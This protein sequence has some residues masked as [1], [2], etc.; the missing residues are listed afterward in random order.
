M[1]Y[2]DSLTT[3]S[4]TPSRFIKKI[5]EG[6]SKEQIISEELELQI[7]YFKDRYSS[8][9]QLKMIVEAN[10]ID[11]SFDKNIR[12]EELMNQGL[13]HSKALNKANI[14]IKKIWLDKCL[15]LR[16]EVLQTQLPFIY[17]SI[18]SEIEDDLVKDN[19]YIDKY[20][21]LD[22]HKYCFDIPEYN[23]KCI[24]LFSSLLGFSITP[25]T[26]KGEYLL[27]L[28]LYIC[29]SKKYTF[30]YTEDS[31]EQKIINKQID[32]YKNYVG[33]PELWHILT[34]PL[35]DNEDILPIQN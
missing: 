35:P 26:L 15:S 5:K 20:T 30:N 2:S 34:S 25:I 19:E 28:N 11:I 21:S 23:K 10:N 4:V 8:F 9:K 13:T 17:D 32:N 7:D 33:D 6:I 31:L 12:I 3:V 29:N 18:F 16:A 24:I 1:L 22:F 14:E 27:Q